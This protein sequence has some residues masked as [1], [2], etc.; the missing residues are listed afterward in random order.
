MTGLT[1]DHQDPGS[2]PN[3]EDVEASAEEEDLI[4]DAVEPSEE[5]DLTSFKG[6]LRSC[7]PIVANAIQDLR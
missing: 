1:K 7:C 5:K 2:N 3:V 6:C 4:C